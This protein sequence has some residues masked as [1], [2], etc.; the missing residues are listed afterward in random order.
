MVDRQRVQKCN[1]PRGAPAG[2][3]QLSSAA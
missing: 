1:S 3:S 2:T